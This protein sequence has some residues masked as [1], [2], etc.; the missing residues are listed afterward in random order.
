M[1]AEHERT[2][3]FLSV[4][5]KRN[6]IEILLKFI[7]WI[8]TALTFSLIV[9]I[10]YYIL[11][12]GLPWLS[13][14]FIK[15]SYSELHPKESGILPMIINT[16]YV[17][18][19]TLL[20]V[21]PIGVGSTIYL[22]FYAR[23]VWVTKMVKI[24][25]EILSGIPSI[26]FGL[27]GYYVFCSGLKLGTSILSGCLTMV[28]CLL[29]TVIRTSEEALRTV[30]KT[31]FEAASSL[32]ASKLKIILKL[33]LPNA[34]SGIFTGIVLCA[35]RVIGESAALIYTA[36]MAYSMPRS[37]FGHVFESGRTLTLHLYQVAKQANS[38]DAFGLAF[39]ASSVLILVIF[40]L[41]FVMDIIQKVS[42]RNR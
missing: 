36:G 2:P 9:L 29:P 42:K 7:M 27:F 21:T 14:N 5:K 41:N 26:I 31:Y 6:K 11:F 30:P 23:R 3:L 4:S 15:N 17:V 19:I 22:V 28:L 33:I 38:K 13:F 34:L 35:A 1:M 24:A 40:V 18:I 8:S 25:S 12:N 10:I 39:A 32:G 20:I 16:L 37:I